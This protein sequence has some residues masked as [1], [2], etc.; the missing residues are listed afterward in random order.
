MYFVTM[1][2]PHI[3]SLSHTH[4]DL[5]KGRSCPS[6]LSQHRLALIL[7]AMKNDLPPLPQI[8]MRITFTEFIELQ[9]TID[10][11]LLLNKETIDWSVPSAI[12]SIPALSHPHTYLRFATLS[13]TFPYTGTLPEREFCQNPIRICMHPYT[14]QIRCKHACIPSYHTLISVSHMICAL[15]HISYVTLIRFVLSVDDDVKFRSR[16]A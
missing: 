5:N 10:L 16:C 12:T 11:S 6:V 4:T 1:I 15:K 7:Q 3:H 14:H 8:G 2:I 9:E 13:Y